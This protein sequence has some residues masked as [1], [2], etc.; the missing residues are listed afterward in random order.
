MARLPRSGASFSSLHEYEIRL[1]DVISS[2]GF[3]PLPKEDE[4]F[5]R[6]K[7]GEAIGQWIMAEGA[8]QGDAKLKHRRYPAIS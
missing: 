6:S 5:V 3:H 7:M 8:Y 2:L 1:K 4:S